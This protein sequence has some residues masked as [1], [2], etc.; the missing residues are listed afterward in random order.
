MDDHHTDAAA[1]GAEP[2]GETPGTGVGLTDR[3]RCRGGAS[4]RAWAAP[5]SR[6]AYSG[7]VPP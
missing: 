2:N 6:S 3:C 5:G 7:T 1:D 4:S